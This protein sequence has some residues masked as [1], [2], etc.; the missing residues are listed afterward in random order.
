MSSGGAFGFPRMPSAPSAPRMPSLSMPRMPSG[1][2]GGPKGSKKSASKAS[3][4][5]D[6]PTIANIIMLIILSAVLGI[7]LFYL[8]NKE[9]NSAALKNAIFVVL[10]MVSVIAVT[11]FLHLGVNIWEV[12]IVSEINILCLV[13]FLSYLSITTIFSMDS[14]W[15]ILSYMKDL[16]GIIIHPTDLFKKGFDVIIP[17]IFLTIPIIVLIT[18]IT[19]NLFAGL[20]IVLISCGVV[21]ILW[22]EN[23]DSPIV[24]GGKD[25]SFLSTLS[26][27]LNSVRHLV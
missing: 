25:P 8:H 9:S 18:N 27:V 22:P 13:F 14:F 2:K 5:G 10:F 11:K 19:K 17:T 3:N 23:L 26:N 7:L 1:P 4:S 16:F 15:N 21:F 12:I 24:E 20:F 6:K